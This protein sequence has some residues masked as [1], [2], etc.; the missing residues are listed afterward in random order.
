MGV[1]GRFLMRAP[2]LFKQWLIVRDS[3]LHW[4]E[5]TSYDIAIIEII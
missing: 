1:G 3:E 5:T 2:L 4:D